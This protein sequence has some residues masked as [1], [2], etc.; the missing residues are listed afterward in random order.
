MGTNV[1]NLICNGSLNGKL[2]KRQKSRSHENS[3]IGIH[4]YHLRTFFFN[5]SSK[6]HF[7][8]FFIILACRI[9]SAQAQY[10]GKHSS[11]S[12]QY[13]HQT[14][15]PQSMSV[16]KVNI[17]PSFILPFYLCIFPHVNFSSQISRHKVIFLDFF[18]LYLFSSYL[19][20]PSLLSITLSFNPNIQNKS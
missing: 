13:F 15:A 20:I 12:E 11:E 4:F 7:S 18:L 9:C 8:P 19:F 3:C 10:L 14:R 1:A 6:I 5:G 2:I 16:R 17:H